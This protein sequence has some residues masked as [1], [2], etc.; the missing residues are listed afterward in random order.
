M[1]ITG[2]KSY[3]GTGF[4]I[5]IRSPYRGKVDTGKLTTKMNLYAVC[6]SRVP[7]KRYLF[8]AAD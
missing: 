3:D 5:D 7:T 1:L 6:K 2:E 4:L 8:M